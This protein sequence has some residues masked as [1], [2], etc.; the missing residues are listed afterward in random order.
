HVDFE[1]MRHFL[2]HVLNHVRAAIW[3]GHFCCGWG[4]GRAK[5]DT[6]A[7]QQSHA[8]VDDAD[9]AHREEQWRFLSAAWHCG[10]GVRDEVSPMVL[11]VTGTKAVVVRWLRRHRLIRAAVQAVFKIVPSPVVIVL[12]LSHRRR[13]VSVCYGKCP[14]CAR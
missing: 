10:L 8:S 9:D 7:A 14:S 5:K 2:V 12:W 4:H 3:G 13:G 6:P 1:P 11:I